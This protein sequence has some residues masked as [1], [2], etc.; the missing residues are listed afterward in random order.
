[1]GVGIGLAHIQSQG[2]I[3]LRSADPSAAPVIDYSLLENDDDLVQL[4]EAMRLTRKIFSAEKFSRYFV[5]ERLPGS[6]IETDEQLDEYIR[7]TSGLMF[8]PCGTCK[9]G[10]DDTA[11]VDEKLQVRG[12][13]GLWVADASVFPTVPAGNINATCIMVGEK[14]ASLIQ[15]AQKK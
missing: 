5:D 3:R 9:M 14:A 10:Q 4:R 6:L 7:E 2:E 12:L 11:V 15:Q 8:H 13:Q 1:M